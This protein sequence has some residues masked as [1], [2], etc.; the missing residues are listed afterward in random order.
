MSLSGHLS[1]KSDVYSF[2]ITLLELLTGRRAYEPSWPKAQAHILDWLRPALHDR[3]LLPKF[4]DALLKDEY[5]KAAART[6]LLI[7]FVCVDPEPSK[8]PKMKRVVQ[9]LKELQD[10]SDN[11]S[12]HLLSS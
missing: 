7:A 9:N 4:M 11:L 5:P 10:S 8:R 3:D 6:V 1:P 2:G 12:K